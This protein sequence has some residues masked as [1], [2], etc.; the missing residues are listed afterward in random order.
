MGIE[1]GCCEI[2]QA[3]DRLCEDDPSSA[4]VFIA[5]EDGDGI[6]QSRRLLT[7][8]VVPPP[9]RLSPGNS[10]L[11]FRTRHIPATLPEATLCQ[12][13]RPTT[14]TLLVVAVCAPEH[15]VEAVPVIDGMS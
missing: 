15:T 6:T 2:L 12:L 11:L 8:S 1:R 14:R 5:G 7:I 4:R 9:S 3:A 10:K 13:S